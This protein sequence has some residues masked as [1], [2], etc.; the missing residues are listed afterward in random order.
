M[1][2][3]ELENRSAEEVFKELKY[4]LDAIG[5][6]PDEY[7]LM[8]KEWGD[9]KMIHSSQVVRI[10]SLVPGEPDYYENSWRL[11]RARRILD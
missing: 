7:I 11:V 10:N 3:I 8:D 6:L 2:V 5:Y 4:R 1:N 9:G